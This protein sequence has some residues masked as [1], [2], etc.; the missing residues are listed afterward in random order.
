MTR[1]IR[2]NLFLAL[3]AGALLVGLGGCELFGFLDTIEVRIGGI[4]TDTHDFG[5]VYG[6]NTSSVTVT[7]T[8][9]GIFPLTLGGRSAVTIG[10]N[11]SGDYS[12]SGSPA[13]T[14]EA[15]SSTSF[16]LTFDPTGTQGLR[17]ATVTITPT[18][19]GPSAT[20]TVSGTYM[21]G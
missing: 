9:T 10:G 3:L 1:G 8:N 11:A 13:T 17:T 20:F 7:I 15:G 18:G 16:V 19:G 2:R 6:N 21:L 4:V 14:I 12:V 5:T